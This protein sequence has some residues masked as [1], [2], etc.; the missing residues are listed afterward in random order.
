MNSET[1]MPASL[2]ARDHRLQVIVLAGGVEPALGR[3]LLALLGHDA[4]GVRAVAQRD[5][6]HLLRSPP[7]RS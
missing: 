4:G 3:P 1:R 5:A 6:D 2:Q 7:S